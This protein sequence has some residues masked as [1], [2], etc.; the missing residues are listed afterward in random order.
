MF[1]WTLRSGHPV[2]PVTRTGA[3]LDVGLLGPLSAEVI[4]F[5]GVHPGVVPAG[6]VQ[7]ARGLRL[8]M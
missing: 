3:G 2:G 7:D 6:L 4:L 8:D 5:D 1:S